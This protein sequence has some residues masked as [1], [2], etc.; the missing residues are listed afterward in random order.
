[1]SPGE[2]IKTIRGKRS[3]AE[4]SLRIG[5]PKNKVIQYETNI[6]TP[7]LRILLQIAEIGNTTVDWLL[8]Q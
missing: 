8:R 2:K 5:K 7:P 1:M 6:S 3:L 4:F